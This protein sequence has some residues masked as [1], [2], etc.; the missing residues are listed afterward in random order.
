VT[1]TG[2]GETYLS[3]EEIFG[4]KSRAALLHL[5]ERLDAGHEL[6]VTQELGLSASSSLARKL[7]WK[8]RAG[9]RQEYELTLDRDLLPASLQQGSQRMSVRIQLTDSTLKLSHDYRQQAELGRAAQTQQQVQ[10]ALQEALTRAFNP[11]V[12]V[13]LQQQIKERAEQRLREEHRLQ[14]QQQRLATVVQER[15]CVIQT[16]GTIFAPRLPQGAY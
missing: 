1:I 13:A 6:F 5:L 10:S 15:N 3:L 11:L 7:A 14:Q 9:K 12:A 4:A 2:A 16:I 8:K